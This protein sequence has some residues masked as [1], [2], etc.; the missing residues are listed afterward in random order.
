MIEL[1]IVCGLITNLINFFRR[2]FDIMSGN[3]LVKNTR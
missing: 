1:K 3:I 2:Q